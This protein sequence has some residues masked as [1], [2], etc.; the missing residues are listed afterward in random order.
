MR[1]SLATI[2]PQQSHAYGL[3][4]NLQ[5]TNRYL[6]WLRGEVASSNEWDAYDIFD[7]VQQR[8][9]L[10]H[11]LAFLRCSNNRENAEWRARAQRDD[12]FAFDWLRADDAST[13]VE[14]KFRAEFKIWRTLYMSGLRTGV[15]EWKAIPQ[16][17]HVQLE[18]LVG[19]DAR[20]I[21]MNFTQAEAALE[22][23]WFQEANNFNPDAQRCFNRIRIYQGAG[24]HAS[25][26]RAFLKVLQS[27]V[28][29][30]DSVSAGLLEELQ[31][32]APS[33]LFDADSFSCLVDTPGLDDTD[34]FRIS[35]TRAAID[36][37]NTVL[38]FSKVT[39]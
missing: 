36:S 23:R 28:L 16:A 22:E 20:S 7:K 18:R 6:Q 14:D 10:I 13:L 38:M 37:S 24:R 33:R 4:S 19:D 39:C 27:R 17:V 30:K 25:D 8:E 32:I 31:W 26:D 1:K 29:E 2:V 15:V 35:Q 9:R 34:A 12:S 5:H 3:L 11:A 21:G